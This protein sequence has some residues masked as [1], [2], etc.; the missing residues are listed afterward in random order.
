MS[1]LNAVFYKDNIV[2]LQKQGLL[3]NTA[4]GNGAEIFYLDYVMQYVSTAKTRCTQSICEKLD[5]G[6]KEYYSKVAKQ[7]IKSTSQLDQAIAE[8]AI[9]FSLWVDIE[10]III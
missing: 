2:N 5:S 10:K 6:V 1:A 7:V 9:D 8:N 4:I 3:L